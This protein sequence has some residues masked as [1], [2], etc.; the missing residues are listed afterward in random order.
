ML[1]VEESQATV[2]A[3]M[4]V[5]G[6]GLALCFAPVMVDMLKNGVPADLKVRAGRCVDGF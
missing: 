6:L 2:F 4:T 3:A 1:S 5:L